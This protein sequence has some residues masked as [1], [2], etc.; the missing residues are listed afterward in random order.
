MTYGYDGYRVHYFQSK[1][2]WG[3]KYFLKSLGLKYHHIFLPGAAVCTITT[4]HSAATAARGRHIRPGTLLLV[5]AVPVLQQELS[6]K[7]D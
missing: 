1:S 4:G 2:E 5:D 7:G 6:Q 3:L